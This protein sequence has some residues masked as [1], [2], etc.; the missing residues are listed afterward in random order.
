MKINIWVKLVQKTAISIDPSKTFTD[1]FSEISKK[2][3][4]HIDLL[5]IMD[6]SKPYTNEANGKDSLKILNLSEGCTIYCGLHVPNPFYIFAKS[7]NMSTPIKID[8]LYQD[9]TFQVI[10]DRF[11]QARHMPQPDPKKIVALA[12]GRV[13]KSNDFN[14]KL[15]YINGIGHTVL[16][17]IN[18]GP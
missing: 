6:N 14:T 16:V 10:L 4:T 11:F 13:I 9:D 15:H 1:L 12:P 8:N 7:S 18:W 5:C 2:F 3:R 17:N